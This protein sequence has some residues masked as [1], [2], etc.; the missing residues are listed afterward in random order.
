MSMA[1]PSDFEKPIESDDEDL[2]IKPNSA[3]GSYSARGNMSAREVRLDISRNTE[4]KLFNSI[5]NYFIE[6][7]EMDVEDYVSEIRQMLR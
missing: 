5:N 1:L 4:L 2:E 7:N 3:R 6:Q